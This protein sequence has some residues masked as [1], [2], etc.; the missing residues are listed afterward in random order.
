MQSNTIFT[1]DGARLDKAELDIL[2]F[3]DSWLP[4]VN[5]W[6]VI[7]LAEKCNLFMSDATAAVDML[8]LNGLME[9]DDGEDAMMGRMVQVPDI[10]QEWIAVNSD[11]IHRLYYMNDTSLFD[12]DE[13]ATA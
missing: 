3:V 11:D 7:D 6:S 8:I 4:H 9:N 10:A 1:L 2:H 13:T 12:E 5:R